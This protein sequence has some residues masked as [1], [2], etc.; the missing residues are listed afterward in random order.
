MPHDV[1]RGL[2]R[3][4]YFLLIRI[5]N[6]FLA[7]SFL[8]ICRISLWSLQFLLPVSL[9]S[10]LLYVAENM[11]DFLSLIFA[12]SLDNRWLLI[13]FAC[14]FYTFMV[15]SSNIRHLKAYP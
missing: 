4:F 14:P 10:V 8:V 12:L 1:G 11:P 13:I 5:P 3:T 15:T 6:Y 7:Q 2:P 9:L